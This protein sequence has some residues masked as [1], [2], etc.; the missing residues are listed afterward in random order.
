MDIV[1]E[2]ASHHFRQ[3]DVELQD[4]E[5]LAFYLRAVAMFHRFRE[6]DKGADAAENEDGQEGTETGDIDNELKE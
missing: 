5:A 6:E 1:P 2:N 4:E 3:G